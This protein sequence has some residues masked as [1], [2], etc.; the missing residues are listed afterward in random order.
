MTKF[1]KARI[2][3]KLGRMTKI[4][5]SSDQTPVANRGET[6][7]E[8]IL[9]AA[10]ELLIEEGYARFSSRGVASR[11]GLR[12]SHV[13]YYFAHAND[14][15]VTLLERFIADYGDAVLAQFRNAKGAPEKRLRHALNFLLS[16][17]D[18]RERCSIFMLEVTSLAAR[19][20]EVAA[21]LTRYYAVYLDALCELIGEIEPALK[22]IKRLQRAKACLALIEGRAM[23]A[24]FTGKTGASDEASAVAAAILSLLSPA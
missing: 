11:A 23:T 2:S 10:A 1:V 3:V 6:R 12:L 5:K 8:E 4:S 9:S 15:I 14:M 7:R 21:A 13:Q 17:P 24:P 19:H 16:D 22:G 18:Y 20:E